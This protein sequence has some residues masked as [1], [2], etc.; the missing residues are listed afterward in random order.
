LDRSYKQRNFSRQF[1]LL[2]LCLIITIAFGL[3]VIRLEHL[4]L[5][6]SL[7][8]ATNGL[9]AI[10]LLRLK[11]PVPFLQNNFGRETLFIYLLGF[12]LRLYG[13]SIFSFRFV[14]VIVAVLSVP[15]IYVVSRQ[16]NLDNLPFSRSQK[17][18]TVSLLAATGLALSYWHIYFS[19]VG[20]R[21]IL[22]PPLML[23]LIW[24]F[25]RGWRGTRRWWFV[26]AGFLLGLTF[27]TYLAARLLPIIFLIFIMVELL[28]PNTL[29][30][31]IIIDFLV[32]N[33]TATLV[34]LPL[35]RYFLQHPQA[36]NSRTQTLSIL[37][38]NNPFPLFVNNLT[39]LLQILFKAGGWLGQWP[40]LDVFMGLGL[41]I[42][43]LICL[44]HVKKSVCTFLLIWW[45]VGMVPVLISQQ[46][47]MGTTTLLRGII[48]W[49]AI[50]LIAAIGLASLLRL[51]FRFI[52]KL[53]HRLQTVAEMVLLSVVFLFGIFASTT[54]Y[55][56]TWA[57]TYNDF[58]DHPPYLARYLNRQTD[59]LTLT[60]LKFYRETVGNFLLQKKYSHLTNITP[61]E[62]PH[63]L[64]LPQPVV[65]LMPAD[66]DG[67][68]NFVLLNPTTNTAYLLPALTPSQT[69]ALAKYSQNAIPLDTVLDSEQEPIVYVYPL[70]G[71][72][73]ISTNH[74]ETPIHPLHVQFADTLLLTNYQIT[75]TTLNPGDTVTLS[76]NWQARRPFDEEYILFI[77][78]FHIATGQRQGQVN[79]PLTGILFDARRWPIGLT[80]PDSHT[81]T[82]PANAPAGPYRFELGLY[83]A[84]TEER[85]PV[86][87]SSTQSPDNKIILGK[88]HVGKPPKPPQIQL[89]NTQFGNNIALMG[90][91]IKTSSLQPG[92]ILAYQL[93]WQALDSITKDYV[94][95]NHL[96][97]SGG[98]VRA[99]QDTTPGQ[100]HYP[101]SWWDP[102]ELV[103]D[104]Y[105]LTLPSD[106]VPGQYTL[107]IG[108][109]EAKTGQRLSLKNQPQNFVDFPNLITVE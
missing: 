33:L 88:F 99:Q 76:L 48:A 5:S 78:L 101:T 72:L 47:W 7:D 30:F 87:T 31:K 12:A 57:T 35:I 10:R 51:A 62:L 65:Y 17:I 109:Y 52:K 16:L 45:L 71:E 104:P 80:V 84:I 106:L 50:F 39:S 43:L 37:S 100:G 56:F 21:A 98:N 8:E 24:C 107:R 108:L 23:A 86:T 27:Y 1:S 105:T 75:P 79:I 9:D 28:K 69:R 96:L 73:P 81:F 94:V 82:L 53:S 70:S 60:P 11:W 92:Q 20:L 91:D 29:R 95:F 36:L 97:D 44:Y 59:Q 67:E 40:A 3:R 2:F 34:G 102:G 22:L 61:P 90:M 15:L 83:H 4:P 38:A 63:L 103:I 18:H 42:G 13:I 14:S 55:Y 68:S 66:S 49:P 46:D 58:S 32:F 41:S 93:H 74:T 6:L 19:R 64:S 85:L 26:A 25:W 89:E 77:H 54:N